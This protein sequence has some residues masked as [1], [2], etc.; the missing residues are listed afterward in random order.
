MSRFVVSL[1]G[2]AFADTEEVTLGVTGGSLTI[3][4]GTAAVGTNATVSVGVTYSTA[5]INN[6]YVTDYRGSGAGWS[7]TSSISNVGIYFG[8]DDDE[9]VNTPDVADDVVVRAITKNGGSTWTNGTALDILGYYNGVGASDNHATGNSDAPYNAGEWKFTVNATGGNISSLSAVTDGN[10]A[11]AAGRISNVES[12]GGNYY[13]FDLDGMKFTFN[14]ALVWSDNDVIGI[15]LDY[16]E[17]DTC[18]MT[19]AIDG[20]DGPTEGNMDGVYVGAPS[21]MAGTIAEATSPQGTGM[22]IFSFD[23]SLSC[24]FHSNSLV[25]TYKALLTYSV[26]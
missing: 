25:G 23:D 12:S 4:A 2:T 7:A 15:T 14:D 26:S 22:G 16:Q 6:N 11:S 3:T 13:R 18:T 24:G 1:V 17:N 5:T 21:A 10:N 20:G 9:N 19:P 8:D